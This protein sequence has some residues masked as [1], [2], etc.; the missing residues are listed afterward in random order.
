MC[1]RRVFV[2][3]VVVALS[4]VF[5]CCV[6][7]LRCVLVMFC[8]LL[9]RVVCHRITSVDR[10]FTTPRPY[11][12]RTLDNAKFVLRFRTNHASACPQPVKRREHW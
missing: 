6:V 4:V 8:C 2:G 9:M 7:G 3:G 5:G 1:F 11:A 10:R 12:R